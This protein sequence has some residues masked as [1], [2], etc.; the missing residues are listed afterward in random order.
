MNS[1]PKIGDL[2]LYGIGDQY[3]IFVG[4]VEYN[5][6]FSKNRYRCYWPW[7]TDKITFSTENEKHLIDYRNAFLEKHNYGD[8]HS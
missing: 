4:V 2:L 3:G 5:S 1:K 7:N 6:S 8:E